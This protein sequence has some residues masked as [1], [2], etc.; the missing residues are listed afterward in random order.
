MIRMREMEISIEIIRAL[1]EQSIPH[2]RIFFFLL[3]HIPVE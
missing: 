2:L 1:G 3:T